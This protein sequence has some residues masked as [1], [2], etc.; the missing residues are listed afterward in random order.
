MIKKLIFTLVLILFIPSLLFSRNT[1]DTEKV[2]QVV[3]AFQDDFNSGL[4]ANANNYTTSDWVHI[5]PAGGVKYGREEV[6]KEVRAVHQDFLRDV[7]MTIEKITVRFIAPTV[8]IAEVIHSMSTY[9]LPRGTIHKNE[10]Q[11]KTYIVV[12]SDGKWLLTLD[13]NTIQAAD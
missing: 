5:N 3:D 13:Q 7:T 4:F 9:E 2:K 6:L 10:I 1:D 8:A 12:K 11:V